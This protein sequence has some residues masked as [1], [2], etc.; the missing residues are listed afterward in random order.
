[1]Y[2]YPTGRYANLARSQ[3][4]FI[5]ANL[6]KGTL[7]AGNTGEQNARVIETQ[8]SAEGTSLL[9]EQKGDEEM[10]EALTR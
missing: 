3:R 2:V 8:Q 10:L 9:D 5:K 6:S 4:D 1:L 7:P